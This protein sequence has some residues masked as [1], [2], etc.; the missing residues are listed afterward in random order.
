M[1]FTTLTLLS[2]AATGFSAVLP[3]SQYG[4]WDVKYS[5]SAYA[6][7]YQSLTLTAN[8][9]S[10]SYPAGILSTCTTVR[11][12]AVSLNETSSCDNDNFSYELNNEAISLTQSIELPT[13]QTVFGNGTLVYTISSS[14]KTYTAE[15]VVDVTEAIA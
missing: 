6:N 9:T 15:T 11:N 2:L 12:P 8:F 4:A 14:G 3:R 10:E 1:Q 7:G 13:P 5:K